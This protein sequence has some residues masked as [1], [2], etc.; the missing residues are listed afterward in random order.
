MVEQISRRIPS[1]TPLVTTS[2]VIDYPKDT[3]R[4]DNPVIKGKNMENLNLNDDTTSLNLN[5]P[6]LAN[7][8]IGIRPHLM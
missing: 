7:Y 1:S 6:Y 5:S 4:M 3:P 2:K 8:S